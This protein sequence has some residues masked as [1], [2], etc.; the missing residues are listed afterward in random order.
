MSIDLAAKRVTQERVI[1]ADA[2]TIFDIVSDPRMHS[3]MDGSGMLQG[4][5]KGPERL[6]MGA[7]F[8]M[9]M[10][11]YGVPYMI[12]NRVVE[13]EPN[14][15]VAWRHIGRHRWRYELEPQATGTLVRETFDWSPTPFLYGKMLERFEYPKAH[16]RNILRTLENLDRLACERQ[17]ELDGDVTG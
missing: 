1:A 9:R 12:S 4:E 6:T 5:L 2:V 14:R 11:Q 15:L 16:D 7:K 8:G 13:F 3:V 10:K 17:A